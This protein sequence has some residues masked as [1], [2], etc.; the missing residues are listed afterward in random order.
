[1]QEPRCGARVWGAEVQGAGSRG[2]GFFPALLTHFSFLFLWPILYQITAMKHLSIL[3]TLALSVSFGF[4]LADDHKGQSVR[5]A[6][7]ED[8]A[9]FMKL[10]QGMW[11]AEVLSVISDNSLG[12]KDG[13]TTYYWHSVRQNSS[14]MTT[15]GSG[16]KNS[17]RGVTFYDPIAK[18]IV[19]TGVS[20]DGTINKSTHVPRGKQWY[21]ETVIT[22][23]DGSVIKTEIMD[24]AR[25]NK[26]GQNF[27]K[28]L[29]ES[30][31]RA[32][33]LCQPLRVPTTGYERWK[34]LQLNFDA[35][36][37]LEG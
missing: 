16:G 35:R 3:L 15:L 27:Y 34:D 26:P 33:Q 14:C 32:I 1:M 23:P 5:P 36:E 37:M 9:R 13:K 8:F 24:H 28:V 12:N 30:A 22:K 18:A 10:E 19:R 6:T 25:M 7:K 4:V 17:I 21:R 20:S 11:R 29:A 2:D 31:L